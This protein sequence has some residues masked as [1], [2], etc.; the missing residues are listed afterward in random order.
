M[1]VK[2]VYERP[3]IYQDYS[4]VK[5]IVMELDDERNLDEMQDAFDEFLRA[6]SYNVPHRD[7]EE[8]ISTIGSLLDTPPITFDE[9][10]ITMSDS[11]SID[12]YDVGDTITL[13]LDETY[14]TT[15]SKLKVD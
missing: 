5:S 9:S 8:P 10:I 15:T 3:D 14:G 7:E 4:A 1:P 13:N 2:L 12:L 11:D 6:M